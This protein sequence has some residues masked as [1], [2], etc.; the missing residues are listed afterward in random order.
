VLENRELITV[1]TEQ[2]HDNGVPLDCIA[3]RM[4]LWRLGSSSGP[5]AVLHGER[6]PTFFFLFYIHYRA[7]WGTEPYVAL[8]VGA[9]LL[10]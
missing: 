7:P 2:L 4:V 1:G 3:C 9:G 6:R 10:L 5:V 8:G